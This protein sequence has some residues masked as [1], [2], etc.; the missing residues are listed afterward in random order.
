MYFTPELK[1]VILLGDELVCIW[2]SL[3]PER[4]DSAL[5]FEDHASVCSTP[6]D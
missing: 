3:L 1:V 6:Q 2:S 4:K 5:E